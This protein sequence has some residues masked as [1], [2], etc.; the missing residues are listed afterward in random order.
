M[1]QFCPQPFVCT[2]SGAPAW[3][4]EHQSTLSAGYLHASTWPYPVRLH[5]RLNIS[6]R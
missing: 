6:P 4:S 3:A 5:G 2:V 1:Q